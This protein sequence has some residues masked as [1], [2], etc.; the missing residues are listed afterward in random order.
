[1]HDGVRS[2]SLM[3]QQGLWLMAYGALSPKPRSDSLTLSGLTVV[4]SPA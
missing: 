1:M 3:K 2:R 4:W